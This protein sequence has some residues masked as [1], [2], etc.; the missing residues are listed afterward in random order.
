MARIDITFSGGMQYSAT[1]NHRLKVMRLER[2]KQFH[3][4]LAWLVENYAM[5]CT[6][7]PGLC[8]KILGA[9]DWSG[10]YIRYLPPTRQRELESIVATLWLTNK[11]IATRTGTSDSQV[12]KW[13]SSPWA[14]DHAPIPFKKF[15]RLR[16]SLVEHPAKKRL[17]DP[18]RCRR[19]FAVGEKI[20][21]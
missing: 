17:V 10:G 21:S 4:S 9:R 20:T 11:E 6:D 13:C 2:D 18:S 5:V 19:K 12:E 14:V 1:Y 7:M 3:I 8:E 16:Q 15:Q